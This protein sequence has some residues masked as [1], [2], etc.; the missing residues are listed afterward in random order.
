MKIVV[1]VETAG[2]AVCALAV[3]QVRRVC[4]ELSH[5]FQIEVIAHAAGAETTVLRALA[6]RAVE[7]SLAVIAIAERTFVSGELLACMARCLTS[8]AEEVWL[9]DEHAVRLLGRQVVRLRTSPERASVRGWHKGSSRHEPIAITMADGVL[10]LRVHVD[11][12]TEGWWS[13]ASAETASRVPAEDVLA[14]VLEADE[15][16]QLNALLGWAGPVWS[17]ERDVRVSCAVV[18]KVVTDVELDDLVGALRSTGAVADECVV[19]LD[20]R[21]LA[22]AD[23]VLS[24]LGATVQR[25]RWSDD[26]SAARN[27]AADLCKGAWVLVIDA[28]EL[29]LDRSDLAEAI[30]AAERVGANAVT[31][32]VVS[33]GER[34]WPLEMTQVRAYRRDECRW[35]WPVHNVLEG[36]R[37]PCVGS[38]AVLESSYAGTAVAKAHRALPVLLRMAAQEPMD[39][40]WQF[41]LAQVF[42]TLG[43][44]QDMQLASERV[45]S[46]APRDPLYAIG[47]VDLAY[48]RLETHG[49]GSAIEVVLDGLRHHPDH[50]DLWHTLA[51]ISLASWYSHSKRPGVSPSILNRTRRFADA[52]PDVAPRLGLSLQ[53]SAQTSTTGGSTPV[54]QDPERLSAPRTRS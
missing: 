21:S 29:F 13:S 27:F 32:R 6:E 11:R 33:V 16:A 38:S 20:E 1:V 5:E 25:R 3:E 44:I 28:D 31:V 49:R 46:M 12:S 40:R 50:P 45:V 19:V 14:R 9:H 2:D 42:G 8:G 24:A 37:D 15:R 36:V 17:T 10:A 4:A 54:S 7:K 41:Y 43:K 51:S 52:L 35:K 22:K 53:F 48:T 23:H 47:W 18:A 34:G 39:P 26:F 30:P